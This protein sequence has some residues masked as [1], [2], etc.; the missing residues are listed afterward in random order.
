MF[1]AG[2]FL[3][4]SAVANP[5]FA[6]SISFSWGN[7]KSCTTGRPNTVPNPVFN[8]SGVP[9]GTAKIR[10]KM[11]DKAVPSYNHGGGTVKYSGGN[12][13]ASGAFKY[14]SPCPP[15]G[16]HPYEWTATAL[17]ASGKKL[18]TAKARRNYP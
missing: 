15:N 8:L 3:S 11:V 4:A 13:I 2:L 6:F 14:K 12:K 5:A 16:S 10:F 18:G 9:K 1:S 7:L 17:D